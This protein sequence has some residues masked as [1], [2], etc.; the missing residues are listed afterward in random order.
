MVGMNPNAETNIELFY[1]AQL[2]PYLTIRPDLQYVA[3]PSGRYRDAL[4]FGLRFE[5]IL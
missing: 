5:V 4:V 1:K 3:N 2:L